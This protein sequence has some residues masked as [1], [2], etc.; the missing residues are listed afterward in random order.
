MPGLTP[1][2][3]PY[4]ESGDPPTLQSYFQ[5]LAEA[6]DTYIASIPPPVIPPSAVPVPVGVVAMT[7]ALAAPTNWLLCRGQAVSRATYSDLFAAFGTRFGA[8]DGSTTFNVPN[9]QARLPVGYNSG[10][11]SGAG[12]AGLWVT[13]VGEIGGEPATQVAAHVH[14]MTH[15]HVADDNL[16][17]DHFHTIPARLD[18]VSGSLGSLGVSNS[19]GT[20]STRN[21]NNSGTH[22]HDI[23]VVNITGNTASAGTT[24]LAGN[25]PPSLSVNY[26]VKALAG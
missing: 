10:S 26:I 3:F 13:G 7:G 22:N 16:A 4:P 5:E 8:G 9:F 12:L 18:P 2:G 21:S 24:S 15:G 20:I 1:L 14:G 17:G 23:T 6:V 25:Y 11:P 19:G